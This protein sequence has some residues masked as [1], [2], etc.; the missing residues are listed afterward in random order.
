MKAR[1]LFVP[2]LFQLITLN[3]SAQDDTKAFEKGSSTISAGLGIGNVWKSFLEDFTNYP[4]NSYEV[5]N[6][7][8]YTLIYEYGVSNK[9]SAG[10]AVG[11]SQVEGYFNGAGYG[12]TFTEKLTNF[13]VLARANYHIGNFKKFDPYVG[14]GLG[15]FHFKY[16]NDN[17]GII[18]SKSPGAFGYSAQL[19]LRYYVLP[20]LAAFAEGGYVGGSLVQLGATFKF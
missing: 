7:G 3:I 12:I 8:T 16:S 15:Y 10:L 13:S 14:G 20:Q 11:Y 1:F 4:E 17:P 2:I 5:S 18:D 9:F 6:N 19:G